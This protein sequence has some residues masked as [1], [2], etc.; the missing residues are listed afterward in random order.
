MATFHR[1]GLAILLAFSVFKIDGLLHSNGCQYKNG[2]IHECDGTKRRATKEEIGLVK[3]HRREQKQFFKAQFPPGF[4]F[5]HAPAGL[6]HPEF[7]D[8][9]RTC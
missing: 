8:L 3:K 7:P 1:L 4:P 5:E 6:E 9:C 2:L